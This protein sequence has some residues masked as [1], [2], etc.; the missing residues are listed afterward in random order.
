MNNKRFIGCCIGM[1]L[2][3]VLVSLF[4]L[5]AYQAYP[6]YERVIVFSGAMAA[7]IINF[8]LLG[9]FKYG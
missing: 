5:A 2:S 7:L 1:I 8:I 6:T 3:G 4:M 9:I